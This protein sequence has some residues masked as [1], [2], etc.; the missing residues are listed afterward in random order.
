MR[1]SSTPE[2]VKTVQQKMF[3][4][5]LDG[6]DRTEIGK[7][8]RK[9]VEDMKNPD[10]TPS[11]SFGQPYGIKKKGTFAYNAAMWSNENLDTEF[12]LGDK[13]CILLR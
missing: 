8:L 3:S 10:I 6:A 1:R 12:D 13:P 5:I 4:A 7:L 2:V 9:E 11:I